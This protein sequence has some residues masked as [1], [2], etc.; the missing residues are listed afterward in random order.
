MAGLW[1]GG[2]EVLVS[3]ASGL[4]SRPELGYGRESRIVA[5]VTA[6]AS[7]ALLVAALVAAV[8][9]VVTV[10]MSS[11]CPVYGART[12]VSMEAPSCHYYC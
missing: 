2:R 10:A 6:A 7:V 11:V 1:E 12:T 5:V 9:D 4:S 8:L 3:V